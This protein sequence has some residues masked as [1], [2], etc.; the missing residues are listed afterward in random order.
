M[1]NARAGPTK[2]KLTSNGYET[3]L[4]GNHLGPCLLTLFL[5]DY[6]D[7]KG[8]I[9]FVGS[10]VHYFSFLSYGESKY[11]QRKIHLHIQD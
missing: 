11:F 3:F 5:M 4:Q 7:E 1:N 9:T 8:R 2:F 6:F 10:V